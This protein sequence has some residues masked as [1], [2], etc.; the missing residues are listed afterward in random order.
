MGV[1]KKVLAIS[2]GGGHWV[3]M[4]RVSPALENAEVTYATVDKSYLEFLNETVFH[5]FYTF[6]DVTRWNRIKWLLTAL[7]IF[8]ILLRVRPDIVLSTGALPGYMALRLGKLL[9]S[10]TIWIDSIANAHELSASGKHVGRYAD[11]YLT[12]WKHL[13]RP[14]GP[15]YHGAVL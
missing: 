6:S 2:S 1:K 3:E 10:K 12:Q 14:E 9:G 15:Y 5:A 13:A 4:L 7:Q 11:L 8:V